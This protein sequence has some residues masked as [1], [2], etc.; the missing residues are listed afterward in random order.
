MVNLSIFV[1]FSLQFRLFLFLRLWK[2]T[3]GAAAGS[4][5][6]SGT[7]GSRPYPPWTGWTRRA[8]TVRPDLIQLP[9]HIFIDEYN[10]FWASHC[11]CE[12]MYLNKQIKK[13][14]NI[15]LLRGE[16]FSWSC[17]FFTENIKWFFNSIIVVIVTSYCIIYAFAFYL[18]L[19][20]FE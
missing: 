4:L 1:L 18:F 2:R 16:F 13:K 8:T 12:R 17:V 11:V 3:C 10:F 19:R 14:L 7:W 20:N 9:Y 6:W 15:I 5:I